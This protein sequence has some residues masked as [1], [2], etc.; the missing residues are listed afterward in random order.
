VS[1][2]VERTF[3]DY[4]IQV[5]GQGVGTVIAYVLR[6]SRRRETRQAAFGARALTHADPGA[7]DEAVLVELGTRRTHPS[8]ALT[9]AR[10]VPRG[11]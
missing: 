6:V 2:D 7:R 1:V 4:A 9:Q 10:V 5:G 11:G 3:A 8:R